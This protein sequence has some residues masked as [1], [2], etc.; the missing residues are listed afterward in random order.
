MTQA[1]AKYAAK[2]LLSREMDK[3]KSKDVG[4]KYVSHFP[5]LIHFLTSSLH[6]HTINMPSQIILTCFI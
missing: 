5:Y 2:K 1:V 4:S 6:L 3:Y